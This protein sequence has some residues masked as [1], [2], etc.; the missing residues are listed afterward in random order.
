MAA[1]EYDFSQT[2]DQIIKRAL[3]IVGEL[4]DDSV[5]SSNALSDA[6]DALNAMVKRWQNDSIFLWTVNMTTL[7]LA[8]DTR[9]YSL[10]TDPRIL[11]ID[12]GYI[13]NPTTDLNDIKLRQISFSDYND[14]YDKTSVGTPTHFSVDNVIPTP[15]VYLWPVPYQEMTF[16][17]SGIAYLKDMDSGTDAPNFPSRWIDALVYGLADALS[18]EYLL[19]MTERDRITSKAITYKTE[20][21]LGNRSTSESDFIEGAY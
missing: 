10:P 18:D 13:V 6:S 7:T 12:A 3:R 11:A 8:A 4:A 20:G 16:K 2:R 1:T 9:S 15:K 21:K 19:P 17:Y 14:T 5:P